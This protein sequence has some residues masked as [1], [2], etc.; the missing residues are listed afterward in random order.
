MS[1]YSHLKN[2]CLSANQEIARN[3]LAIST[4]GNVSLADREKGVFVIKPSGVHYD[5]LSIDSI[6]VL[7]FQGEIVE[8]ELSPSSDTKTHLHLYNSWSSIN[9]ICHTHSTYAVGWSQ[10]CRPVPILGTT[11]ADHLTK[12]IPCTPVMNNDLIL[13][14]YEHNTGVQIVSHFKDLGLLETEVQMCLVGSHGPFTWGQDELISVYNSVVLE[15]I[16]KM[17]FITE[18]LNPKIQD[19]KETLIRKHYD[20]KHGIKS[21]YGQ[22]GKL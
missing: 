5:N 13:G 17:S 18:S 10:S 22:K 4:F 2:R 8:G 19:I 14:D 20:R 11:H 1:E 21:Y 15:E 12:K 16:C 3:K 9:S 7:N 6:V